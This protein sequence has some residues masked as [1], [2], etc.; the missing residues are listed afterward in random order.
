MEV[1]SEE[2]L[3]LH[4]GLLDFQDDNNVFMA[5]VAR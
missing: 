1:V 4:L 3:K 5:R 2:G